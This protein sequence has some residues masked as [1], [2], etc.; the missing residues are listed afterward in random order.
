MRQL[1]SNSL[2]KARLHNQVRAGVSCATGCQRCRGSGSFFVL[3]CWGCAALL[4][5]SCLVPEVLAACPACVAGASTACRG[6]LSGCPAPAYPLIKTVCAGA[7]RTAS[8]CVSKQLVVLVQGVQRLAT[9][10]A[11]TRNT[12]CILGQGQGP[13]KVTRS[14]ACCL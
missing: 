9:R 6:V 7:T 2:P 3:V 8:A 1:V 14:Y 11:S 4:P 13:A 5:P 12:S 10:S